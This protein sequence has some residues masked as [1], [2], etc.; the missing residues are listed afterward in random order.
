[1]SKR[2][3]SEFAINM[4]LDKVAILQQGDLEAI[5]SLN[6]FNNESPC[7]IYFIC[8]RP[9]VSIDK[10][11]ITATEQYI[12]LFFKIQREESFEEFSFKIENTFKTTDIS[13]E[14]KYPNTRF[15]LLVNGEFI[16]RASVAVFLQQFYQYLEKGDFL[17]LE[18]LYVGQSYGV[19]GARTAPDRLKS[20]STLQNIYSKSIQNNPDCE[21][22]LVLTSFSQINLMMFD[23]RTEF[24]EEERENDKER[25]QK[26]YDKLNWEGINEQQKINFTEAALIKYFEP[27]YNKIYKETF[28]NPAHA[29]Y[30]ECYDLDVNAVC[31]ELQTFE[32][33]N[34]CLFSQKIKSAPW[35][36]ENFPLH[37]PEERKSMFD[38]V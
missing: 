31:I 5:N 7:H 18:V 19:E 26:V 33:A 10:S 17:D 24:T 14:S 21:I 30:S 35:H 12:E 38:W 25:F 36:M 13:I 20:H 8:K 22:W 34:F 4:M 2:L 29:T 11:R 15:Q 16:L 27:P 37:S 6:Y 32:Q 3:P 28:P 9:R 1:M 23:G